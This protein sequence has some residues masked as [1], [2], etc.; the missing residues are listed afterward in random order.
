M[1]TGAFPKVKSDYA[2]KGKWRQVLIGS[3]GT[4]NGV[5]ATYLWS[6]ELVGKVFT[7][8]KGNPW[9]LE[10]VQLCRSGAHI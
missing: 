6:K 7:S 9:F 3:A 1:E 8:K 5:K 2:S 10:A 4:A